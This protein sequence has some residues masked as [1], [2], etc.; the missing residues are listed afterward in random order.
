MFS[1]KGGSMS[2]RV[3]SICCALDDGDARRMMRDC[4][5]GGIFTCTTCDA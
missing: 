4:I 5:H 1:D 2:Y 3:L